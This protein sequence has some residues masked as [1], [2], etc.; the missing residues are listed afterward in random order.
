M[1]EMPIKFMGIFHK[2]GHGAK[3]TVDRVVD[4]CYNETIERQERQ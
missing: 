1:I 3:N 4:L 2:I